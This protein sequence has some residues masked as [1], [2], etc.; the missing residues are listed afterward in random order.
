MNKSKYFMK[1]LVI[2]RKLICEYRIVF[3]EAVNFLFMLIFLPFPLA[4]IMMSSCV[5]SLF[6]SLCS[7]FDLH[8]KA[9]FSLLIKIRFLSFLNSQSGLISL[10]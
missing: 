1:K 8:F 2:L 4:L 5:L 3:L 9:Q 6:Q 10:I 7:S